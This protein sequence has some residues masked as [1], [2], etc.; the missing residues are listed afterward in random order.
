MS[1]SSRLIWTHAYKGRIASPA[2]AGSG[3][4]PAVGKSASVVTAHLETELKAGRLPALSLDYVSE[5]TLALQTLTPFLKGFKHM[6][7]LGIGGSSLGG[8]ALQK[9]FAPEADWPGYAGPWL[10][11]ADNVDAA[12]LPAWLRRLPAADTLVVVISKSGGTIET[13]AQYLLVKEWLKES[14]GE[15]WTDHVLPVTD[16]RSGFLRQEAGENG[17]L[18]LPVPEHLGGRYSV[19]SAVGLVPA[20]FLGADW[21]ALLNGA[22][23]VTR[24]LLTATDM[25]AALAEHPAWKLAKWAHALMR[26]DYSQLIFFS[27][28]PS[29]TAMGAWFAQLWAESLGKNGLGSMPLPAVGAT[30]QHSLQQMFLDGPKDKG[31]IFVDCPGLPAGPFF[32]G[33]LPEKWSFLRGHAFGDLLNA[34]SLGT[35]MALAGADM[36]I[37]G[38]RLSG[39]SEEHI[40]GL[41]ALLELTT[42]FTGFDMGI[43]PLDQPA[44]EL[45]K[46]LA[47]A[48]L[49]AEGLA[50][51][52]Q[53]LANFLNVPD[54][55]QSF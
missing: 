34:E 40:G 35:R 42:M 50:E 12:A 53:M 11:V 14:C 13:M 18:S 48:Y 52:K 10:W 30:D 54:K 16:K 3:A 27:Y 38:L 26:A 1:E 24:P 28:I 15:K 51:E 44:V 31:C 39:V 17:M 47:N 29:F 8:R 23:N 33:N 5:L 43:D 41:M 4:G 19:L 2:A 37:V 55:E 21:Q 32:P 46:R 49:G 22:A 9:I 45:G 7:L 25:T 36:P 20:A 6:L